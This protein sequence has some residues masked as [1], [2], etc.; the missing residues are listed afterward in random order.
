MKTQ[1][2]KAQ[3]W[4]DRDET[5]SSK[6]VQKRIKQPWP[7][8]KSDSWETVQIGRIQLMLYYS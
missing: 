7:G 8:G 1:T 4:S 2:H 3:L 6:L 5:I